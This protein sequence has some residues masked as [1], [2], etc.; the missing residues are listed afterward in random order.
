M[1]PT[2]PSDY[3]LPTILGAALPNFFQVAA[4]IPRSTAQ[5]HQNPFGQLTFTYYKREAF[6][7][8][9]S[10]ALPAEGD[11]LGVAVIMP[12][13]FADME[14]QLSSVASSYEMVLFI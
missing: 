12:T 3:I 11:V 2:S 5:L 8:K 1:F 6:S 14:R 7:R 13:M 9:T 10:A 4:R